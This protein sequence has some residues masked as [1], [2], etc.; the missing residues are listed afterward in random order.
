MPPSFFFGSLGLFT[1]D[2]TP[3]CAFR[4]AQLVRESRGSAHGEKGRAAWHG[5]TLWLGKRMPVLSVR[6]RAT[7]FSVD[8]LTCIASPRLR[9]VVVVVGLGKSLLKIFVVFFAKRALSFAV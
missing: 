3:E 6:T 4:F 2:S 1:S 8:P 9:L 5:N 7:R